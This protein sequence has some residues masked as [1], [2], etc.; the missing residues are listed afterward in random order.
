MTALLAHVALGREVEGLTVH[1][2]RQLVQSERSHRCVDATQ[3][4]LIW[5]QQQQQ[6]GHYNRA[7][8]LLRQ[9]LHDIERTG[10]VRLLLDC[11]NL[12][13]A[14]R[15]IN[16]QYASMLVARM[17]ASEQPSLFSADLTAQEFAILVQLA[18]GTRIAEI[19]DILVIAPGTV[20]WHLTNLYAKLG[21]KN[22]REAVALALRNGLLAGH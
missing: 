20:K 7:R 3:I 11:P 18:K 21:V 19:A 10:Y 15:T 6:L 1:L 22:Q 17:A 16:T 4:R 9:A 12:L 13:P 2:E 8:T 5:A 14:V